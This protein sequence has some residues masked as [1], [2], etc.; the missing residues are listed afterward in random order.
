M[1]SLQ[2]YGWASATGPTSCNY[3]SPVVLSLLRTLKPAKVLDLGAGTEEG[4]FEVCRWGGWTY[5]VVVEK[6]G[7]TGAK[8][9]TKKIR[10][11]KRST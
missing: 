6:H 4:G 8:E 3:I 5:A 9:N 10:R 7:C 1:S 2:K 11:S